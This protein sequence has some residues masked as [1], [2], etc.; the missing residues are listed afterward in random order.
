VPLPRS[1]RFSRERDPRVEAMDRP[2]L[3][4][5]L[6]EE[7][8]AGLER[9]RGIFLR[10]GPLL[11][12]LVRILP[13]PSSRTLRLVELGAGTGEL[14]ARLGRALER[15][16]RRVEMVATD[17]IGSPGVR[18]F[19]CAGTDGWT[20]ADLFFSNLLL[21]HLG[22]DEIRQSL[23]MQARH[24]RSGS[25]HL[26]VVRSGLSYYLTRVFLPLLRYPRIN[27]SD[28]LL[29]IQ[30]AFRTAELRALADGICAGAEVRRIPPF[31]QILVCKREAPTFPEP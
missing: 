7:S 22:V 2:D 25:V 16:G 17:R 14:S 24:A 18:A 13:P 26:D 6:R 23:G 30:A 31:R 15:T 12:A 11:A 8:L 27:Q 9:L 20:D 4:P 1:W 19:D 10:P 29:S 3:D 21:H 28:A 5:A